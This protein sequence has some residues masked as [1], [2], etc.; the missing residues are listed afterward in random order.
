ML[1]IRGVSDSYETIRECSTERKNFTGGSN[2][3]SDRSPLHG[4]DSAIERSAS[5]NILNSKQP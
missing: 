5:N 3:T 4:R 2:R 1:A